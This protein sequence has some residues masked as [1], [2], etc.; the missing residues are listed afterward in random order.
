VKCSRLDALRPKHDPVGSAGDYV[1]KS[2]TPEIRE[3]AKIYVR[4]M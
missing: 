2:L 4:R 1:R 3:M